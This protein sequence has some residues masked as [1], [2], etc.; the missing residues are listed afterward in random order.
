MTL[1][2]TIDR[3]IRAKRSILFSKED[4]CLQSLQLLTGNLPDTVVIT[5]A[6]ALAEE[7]VQQLEGRFPEDPRPRQALE[8]SWKWAKGAVKM[9]SARK[10]ILACHAAAKECSDPAD[11]A[12]FHAVGQACSTVHTRGHA[13]GYPLYALTALLLETGTEDCE[14][15]ILQQIES[16]TR[17]LLVCSEAKTDDTQWAPFLKNSKNG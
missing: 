4:A 5:W 3:R 13:M 15:R 9:P 8:L 12:R 7:T 1:Q 10:A 2:E 16:Y 6:L 17:Q 11:A 14:A